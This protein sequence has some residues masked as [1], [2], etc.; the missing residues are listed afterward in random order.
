VRILAM[1]AAAPSVP[2]CAS[3]KGVIYAH[4]ASLAV[5]MAFEELYAPHLRGI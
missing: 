1:L 4:L 2:Y 5:Q 3:E